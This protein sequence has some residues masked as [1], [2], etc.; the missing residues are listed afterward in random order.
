MPLSR[1]NHDAR[2]R[3]TVLAASAAAL[4]LAAACGPA[5]G[6]DAAGEAAAIADDPHSFAR[7]EE[8]RV[9][10]LALDLTVDFEAKTLSGRASL[11]L[12][13]A[14]GA[15][16]LVLDTRGLEI[17]AVTLGDGS[18]AAFTLGDGIAGQEFLGR[19]LTIP[20]TPETEVVHVDYA[21]TP[22]AAALQWLDPAQTA[23]GERPFLFTQSQAILARTWVP[24]QDSPGVRMTYEATVRVPEG[25]LAVMSAENPTADQPGG[26]YRFTM[27]QP[28]PSYLLALAVGELGFESLGAVAGVYAE[29][30]TLPAAAWELADTQRMIDA[31]E[32]LYGPY[33]WGRYDLLVLPPSFPFG[34]MENPRLTFATPTILAGDRSLVSLVAHELAHS[35]SGNLVTNADWNDFWLNEGFTTYFESRIMEAV[36]GEEYAEMLGALAFGQLRGTVEEMGADSPDTRLHLDLAGR[37]PDA[38]LTDIAYEK[39]RFFLATL[40]RAVGRERWDAFLRRYF[41]HFAFRSVTSETFLAYLRRELLTP[42]EAE[43]IGIDEWVYQP[44]LPAGL[45]EPRSDRFAAVDARRQA[46]LD[47]G[48]AAELPTADWTTHEWLHFLRGLPDDLPTARLAELDAA[49]QL[50]AS[51]NAE[52]QAEWFGRAIAA[53]YQP[54]YPALEEFLVRVGRRKF[55]APLYG[56]LAATPEGKEWA[57]RVYERARPGYHAVSRGTIDGILGWEEGAAAAE[58]PAAAEAVAQAQTS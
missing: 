24:C 19:P 46:W 1:W 16:E 52:I 7:P 54:A 4:L 5:E 29:P 11:G 9:T 41:D 57:L 48:P 56:A 14:D 49:F 36:Y 55:L 26:V 39:G 47:G 17:A 18:A 51:G 28:V 23:G 43:R 40:E 45:V 3:R 20:I 25:M 15:R 27:P 53:G 2:V 37:D 34:G 33:R 58:A 31:A 21:T 22:G 30:A 10:H 8:A 6:P 38:G 13:A 35:W 50:T 42:P 12:D 32:Q 44:G